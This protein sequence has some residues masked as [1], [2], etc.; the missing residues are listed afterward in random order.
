MD[1]VGYV[2]TQCGECVPGTCNDS[3][4]LTPPEVFKTTCVPC[5]AGTTVGSRVTNHTIQQSTA[6]LNKS[7]DHTIIVIVT[8]FSFLLLVVGKR[9]DLLPYITRCITLSYILHLLKCSVFM[10]VAAL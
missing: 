1:S 6:Q 10:Y 7:T 2:D 8:V 3:P 5:P 9:I 4:E